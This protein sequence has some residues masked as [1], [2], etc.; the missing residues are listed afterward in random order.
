MDIVL[1][2]NNL[3]KIGE[4]QA[5]LTHRDICVRPQSEFAVP[6]V[7]ETGTTFV[8]NAIIK[9]R[10]ASRH[11]RLP[12]F[13]DDSGISVDALDGAPGVHSARYAG[14]VASDEQN[15][16]KLLADMHAVPAARRHCRF[17]CVI[18]YLTQAHDPCPLI[19]TGVW[20]G[21]L[22]DAPRG[23]RG[24][25]YD[26]IFYV[27]DHDCASAELEPAIKNRI[28]HRGQALNAFITSFESAL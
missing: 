22:L 18:A 5:M 23:T 7:E 20:E 25:G 2:S 15:L 19:A 14:A 6:P 21:L 8:E 11:A 12:A 9:A 16:Q 10:H 13:A 3:G 26:P 27:S 17:I 1:A 24:F 28:S 4:F